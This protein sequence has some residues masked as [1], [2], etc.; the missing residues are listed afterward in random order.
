MNTETPITDAAASSFTT[1]HGMSDDFVP[2]E[3]SRKLEKE[4]TRLR[5]LKEIMIETTG[6]RTVPHGCIIQ[7]WSLILLDGEYEEILE[8]LK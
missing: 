1:G 5:K 3:I 7:Q 2:V 8:L 6:A 4:L